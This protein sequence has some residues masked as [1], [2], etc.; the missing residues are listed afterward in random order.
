MQKEPIKAAAVEKPQVPDRQPPPG[1]GLVALSTTSPRPAKRK[2]KVRHGFDVYEDQLA[3][4]REMAG[5]DLKH[6]GRG[7]MSALVRDALDEYLY[8]PRTNAP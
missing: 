3:R 5:D 8:G 2:I 1:P 7:S 6:G 4:L